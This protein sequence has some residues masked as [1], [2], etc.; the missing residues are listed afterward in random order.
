VIAYF[1]CTMTMHDPECACA[2]VPQI[3]SP[4]TCAADAAPSLFRRTAHDHHAP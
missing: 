2:T 4:A 3:V 1:I